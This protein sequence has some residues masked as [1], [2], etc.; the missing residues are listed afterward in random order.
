MVT[1]PSCRAQRCGANKYNADYVLARQLPW[2]EP[3]AQFVDKRTIDG[4]DW[5]V[6]PDCPMCPICERGDVDSRSSGRFRTLLHS[7]HKYTEDNVAMCAQLVVSLNI[8]AT[9]VEEQ[10]SADGVLLPMYKA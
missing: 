9:E 7:V 4:Q 1:N 5:I 2:P 6:W 3:P 10:P 8:A